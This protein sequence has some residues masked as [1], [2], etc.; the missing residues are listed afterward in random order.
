MTKLLVTNEKTGA[1][2][3]KDLDF[4]MPMY[5]IGTTIGY[6]V[7][8][9]EIEG[10]IEGITTESILV[11]DEIV[12]QHSYTTDNGDEVLEEEVKYYYPEQ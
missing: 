6:D 3:I 2:E 7:S 4:D 11:A 1:L 10:V 8:G 9:I 12:T 5:S